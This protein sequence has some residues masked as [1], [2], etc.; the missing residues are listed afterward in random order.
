MSGATTFCRGNI[1]SILH[2]RLE[3]M[4]I[5]FNALDIILKRIKNYPVPGQKF[6]AI[7]GQFLKGIARGKQA[8]VGS[9]RV[10]ASARLFT[11]IDVDGEVGK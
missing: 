3:N 11:K 6:S 2:P 10:E 5:L 8:Q 1:T 7:I 4:K 9:R